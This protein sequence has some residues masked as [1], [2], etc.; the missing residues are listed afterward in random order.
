MNI[1]DTDLYEVVLVTAGSEEADRLNEDGAVCY[2]HGN[3]FEN[4]YAVVN[5]TT[6]V[7]EYRT[8]VLPEAI[9]NCVGFTT[10]MQAKPWEWIE[11][12]KESDPMDE[13]I[14]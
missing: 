13:E 11:F 5:K 1:F 6:G 4:Y 14:H 9:H 12:E 10:T 2:S 7:V 8:V 3:E